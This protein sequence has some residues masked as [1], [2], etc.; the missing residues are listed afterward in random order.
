M[1]Y[2]KVPVEKF[3]KM[4][5]RKHSGH[6]KNEDFGY[7]KTFDGYQIAFL[8]YDFSKYSDWPDKPFGFQYEF[9]SKGDMRIDMTTCNTMTFK[10]FE[11][12]CKKF[13]KLIVKPLK[14]KS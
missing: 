5:Y 10:E 14:P 8:V 4:G 12:L 3:E 2:N 11:I 6:Y 9:I 7:W 1:Y 13:Y